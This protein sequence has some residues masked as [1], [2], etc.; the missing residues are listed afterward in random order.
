MYGD[1]KDYLQKHF[2]QRCVERVG[3]YLEPLGIIKKIQNNQLEF[4]K[5]KSKRV[6]LWKFCYKGLSYKIA[7][8]KYRKEL[9]TIIP[10]K[11]N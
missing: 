9:I 3:V 2:A 6:T 1:K 5:R 10:I 8:D 11:K 4:I 7:Y